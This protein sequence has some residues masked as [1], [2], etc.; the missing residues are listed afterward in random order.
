MIT[1]RAHDFAGHDQCPREV[2]KPETARITPCL[3][4]PS[5]PACCFENS[6]RVSRVL[7]RLFDLDRPDAL[8]R[9]SGL[10]E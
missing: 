5:A 7:E 8:A 3:V 6:S 1:V 4:V 2:R 9:W 10:L